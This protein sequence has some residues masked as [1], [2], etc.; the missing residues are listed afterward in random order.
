MTGGGRPKSRMPIGQLRRRVEAIER[1]AA[2]RLDRQIEPLRRFAENPNAIFSNPVADWERAKESRDAALKGMQRARE[3]KER[4]AVDREEALIAEMAAT[5]RTVERA[6]EREKAAEE[7][8]EAAEA[9]EAA[10]QERSEA[11]ER[12]M[13]R[14]TVASG[15]FGAIGAIAAVVATF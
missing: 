2:R 1:D 5:R 11:R 6:E 9:R 4:A 14:V 10:S 8:A 15:A 7:R 3:A 13:V 12:F